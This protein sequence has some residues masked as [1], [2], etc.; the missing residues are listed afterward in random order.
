MFYQYIIF[1]AGFPLQNNPQSG[2]AFGRPP[3]ILYLHALG[4][5]VQKHKTA[6]VSG[7]S[8]AG[9]RVRLR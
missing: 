1:F 8:P 5:D 7:L 2:L 9:R 3:A 6:P 4:S